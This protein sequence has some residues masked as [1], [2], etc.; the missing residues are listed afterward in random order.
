MR[1]D[2]TDRKSLNDGRATVTQIQAGGD[3]YAERIGTRRHDDL[4][5]AKPKALARAGIAEDEVG[6]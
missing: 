1:A 4:E 2:E 6:A 3:L 5:G